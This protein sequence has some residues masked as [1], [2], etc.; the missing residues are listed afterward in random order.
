M[1]YFNLLFRLIAVM[2]ALQRYIVC[3]YLFPALIH[4]KLLFCFL[5][6][7]IIHLAEKNDTY[8]AFKKALDENGAE[9]AVS[10]LRLF[11]FVK[12]V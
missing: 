8:A 5:A 7:F 3:I 1:I 6:E 9:F 4:I 12:F 2:F 11:L 10:Y